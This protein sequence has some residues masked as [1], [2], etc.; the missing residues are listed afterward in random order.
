MQ[1]EKSKQ[2]FKLFL[3][4][5]LLSTV[6]CLASIIVIGFFLDDPANQ[7]NQV[8]SKLKLFLFSLRILVA[9]FQFKVR[10]IGFVSPV[11]TQL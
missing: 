3:S 8:K 10:K 9:I 6:G 2:V 11:T 1:S 5:T 7:V 4:D